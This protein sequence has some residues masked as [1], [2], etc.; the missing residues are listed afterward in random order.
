MARGGVSHRV[1]LNRAKLDEAT[2][3]V[4]D[5]FGLVAQ[6]IIDRTSPPD[7]PVIGQGLVANGDWGV[8]VQGKKV[9]GTAAKPRSVRVK[10]Y[11]IVA[12]VGFPFP[13]RFNEIGTSHQPAR[14][15]FTPIVME[16]AP[17]AERIVAEHVGPAAKAAD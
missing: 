17:E 4:A 15:F 1:V 8:W 10:D 16:V 5:G 12:L 13:A 14:P 6:E 9:A 2:L 3:L 11:P 7:A